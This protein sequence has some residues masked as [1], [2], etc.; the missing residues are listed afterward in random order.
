MNDRLRT[1]GALA[2]SILL[3]IGGTLMTGILP[4]TPVYQ[5]LAGIVIVAGFGVGYFVLGEF[6][7]P[8]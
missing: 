2:L 5:A 6:K 3:V 7:L 4:A 8:E 1:Y